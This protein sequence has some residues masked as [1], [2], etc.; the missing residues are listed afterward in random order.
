MPTFF[1]S[2]S[3]FLP[4]VGQNVALRFFFCAYFVHCLPFCY[5]WELSLVV[6]I[7]RVSQQRA[8]H[9]PGLYQPTAAQFHGATS[10]NYS[11]QP[12][13]NVVWNKWVPAVSCAYED[14][15]PIP[16]QDQLRLLHYENYSSVQHDMLKLL[17]VISGSHLFQSPTGSGNQ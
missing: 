14:F 9:F 4:I 1:F 7:D 12:L 15:S 17:P 2:L 11:W 3:Y 10:K 13:W 6:I 16:I 5:N 8:K